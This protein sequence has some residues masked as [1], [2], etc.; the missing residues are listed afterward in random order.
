[1]SL[2]STL[3]GG[4][5]EE[6][7]KDLE[8]ALAA[9]QNVKTPT[10]EEMQF[11][12]QQL[13][14]AGVLTPQQAKT[15]LQN[16]SA[17]GSEDIDQTGTKAQ[18]DVIGELLGAANQ[19]GLNPE[20]QAQ[21]QQIMQQLGTQ[22]RGANDAVLQNQA[23]RGALTGGETLAAQLQNNQNATVNA[24]QNASNTAAT[25]YQQMLNELTSAG[26]LGANLQGQQN[27][28][29]NTVAAATDAI[30]KFNATQQQQQE[31]YNVGNAN[32]AQ[33]ENLQNLQGIENAN[34]TNNNNYSAYQANLPQRVYEDEMRKAQSEASVNE[35]QSNQATGQGNQYLALEGGLVNFLA[36]Q[37]FTGQSAGSTIGGG[38]ASGGGGG[39]GGAGAA[40][41]GGS[42]FEASSA[43]EGAG[44]ADAIFAADEG[45]QVPGQAKEMG[46]SPRNDKVPALL[47]PKE[48]V[49]PRSVAIP[50][51]HGNN[52]KVMDFLQ[53]MRAKKQGPPPVHPHDIKSVL[54]ALS[55]RRGA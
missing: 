13:V 50:A 26:S 5:S 11:K 23:A 17:F 6:S 44:A 12:V 47:S 41:G 55:M 43:G 32:Q 49:L 19:G 9:I 45:G 54:D 21:M 37:P 42:A 46:D 40:A 20:E 27:T 36:P 16:P 34:T 10:A 8:A 25:A 33:S 1:M 2:L 24:N 28:Q 4:K 3:T 35:Q 31:N 30:N 14:Q 39:A 53:R 29:A 15:F 51:M 48:V 38:G 22:E 18:Q 52:D 7:T